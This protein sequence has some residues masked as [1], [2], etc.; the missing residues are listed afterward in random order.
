MSVVCVSSCAIQ[1]LSLTINASPKKR[2][3]SHKLESKINLTNV[4]ANWVKSVCINT[5]PWL[6]WL[7]SMNM[8]YVSGEKHSME[9]EARHSV[10]FWWEEKSSLCAR[11]GAEELCVCTEMWLNEGFKWQEGKVRPQVVS[12]AWILVH[13]TCNTQS[14]LAW[15]AVCF[16][17]TYIHNIWDETFWCHFQQRQRVCTLYNK[18]DKICFTVFQ[19]CFTKCCKCHHNYSKWCLTS[20]T[21]CPLLSDPHRSS[22]HCSSS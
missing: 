3:L 16:P 6:P 8:N 9:C 2:N 19:V 18:S 1:W 12:P 13:S 7:L 21:R 14:S 5:Y 17:K 22:S 15:A 4:R 10:R 20:P 11:R